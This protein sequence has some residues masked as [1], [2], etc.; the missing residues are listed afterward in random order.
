MQIIQIDLENVKSYR[1]ES[2]TFTGG[3]NAICGPNGAGKSTL[4]ESI[5][6]ALFDSLPYSQGQFVR[7]GER[8]AT[9]TIHVVGEDERTYQVVRK[10]GKGNQYYVYDPEIGKVTTG[11][12]DTIAWLRKFLGVEEASDLSM[13]FKDAVG[14]PQGLLT[15]AFLDRPANR[16]NTFD[17]LLR[18]DEYKRV[19]DELLKPFRHV[20]QQTA[21]EETRIAGFEAEVRPLPD[22]ERKVTGLQKEIGAGE[23]RQATLHTELADVSG[24]KMALEAIKARRDAL[25]QGVTRA[26]ADVNT[27][28]ARLA[29]AQADVERAEAAQEVVRKA[30]PGHRAYLAAQATL[31]GLEGQRKER[32]RLKEALQGRTTDMALARQKAKGLE[33]KLQDIAA[34]EAEMDRLRPHVQAQNRLE[35]ELA[36]ARRAADQLANL[37]RNLRQEKARLTKLDEKL[38]QVQ[39]GLVESTRVELEIT[40]LQAD[41]ATLDKRREALT[42]QVAAHRAESDQLR[43]QAGRAAKRVADAEQNLERERKQLS[44]LEANLSSV[45]TGLAELAE[46]EQEMEVLQAELEGLEAQRT[47]LAS[48]L[49]AHQAGL[50]QVRAQTAVLEASESPECPVCGGPLTQEHRAELLARYRAQQEDLEAALETTQV[51]QE[52]TQETCDLKQRALRNLEKRADALPRPAQADTLLAQINTQRQ[53]VTQAETVLTDEQS[54]ASTYRTRQTKLEAAVRE[55]RAEQDELERDRGNKQHVLSQLEKRRKKLPHP[56]EAEDLQAQ[57][58]DQRKSVMQTE[59]EVAELA[60]APAEV[61]RLAAQ[62]DTLGDPRR[63]FQR[64]SDVAN[65]RITTEQDLAATR[66][67]ITTLNAEIEALERQLAAY[68]DLDGRITAE[69]TALVSHETDHLRYLEHIREAETVAERHA[70]VT[71]VSGE[72]GAA[73]AEWEQLVQERN[74][75]AAGYDADAYNELVTRH[76]TLSDELA[77]LTERVRL[78][79][80]QAA[81]GQVE[82]ERLVRVQSTLEAARAERAELVEIQTLLGHIRQVLRDAG[83]KVTKALVEVISL[84]AARLYADIMADHTARLQWAEDYDIQ[85]MTG[86]RE[87]VFQ[88]L[89]GGE[90]M[91]A[92][93]AVRLALLREV[94]GIDVAFFDEPTANL[95]D[96]RRDN[97][98][99]QILNVKGFSQLFVIS[100]DDTFERDTENVVRIVKENGVSRVEA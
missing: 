58:V 3:T 22:L 40:A 20:E 46:I 9:V 47:V 67:R 5:G 7:E 29:D 82:I 100:H 38:L 25:E 66:E 24:Q 50:D 16:K 52:E 43:E 87:R 45:Q 77:A 15:A 63:D 80:S 2:V 74:Q 90:Q 64:A 55:L 6:F 8:T 88:Q 31:E 95:D 12:E 69:Q 28:T 33:T 23:Q 96:E 86:G 98:A 85:L 34:A 51:R 1:R 27:L 94:S 37:K 62:Q 83:P 53:A 70:R 75:V 14:V 32:E 76:S 42:S 10:C 19:W 48:E 81:E 36:E 78:Q 84:Q 99:E 21:V 65:Q 18:V 35:A 59:T 4:L 73:Q 72:L 91:A 89:S 79:R 93:L 97:L 92:A 54:E 11:K 60:D 68:V 71:A 57:I 39:E 56:S 17:P 41:L 13:L 61:E 49:A 26:E 30:E 44:E